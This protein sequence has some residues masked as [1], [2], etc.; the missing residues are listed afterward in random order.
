[1]GRDNTIIRLDIK[2]S[3]KT[4]NNKN[5]SI[6]IS[7]VDSLNLLNHSLD[8]ICKSFNLDIQKGH[9]PHSF[10]KKKKKYSKLYWKKTRVILF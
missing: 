10:V 2:I 7:F 1:M 8:K 4:K 9:F 5:K 6:K 3:T